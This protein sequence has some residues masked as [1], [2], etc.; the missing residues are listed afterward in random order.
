MI[1]TRHPLYQSERKLRFE[2]LYRPFGFFEL[3]E[4]STEEASLHLV[5]LTEGARSAKYGCGMYRQVKSPT[6]LKDISLGSWPG[7][8]TVNWHPAQ[9]MGD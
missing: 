8:L 9:A 2:L 6:F 5:A 3:E 1:D 7:R 4:L